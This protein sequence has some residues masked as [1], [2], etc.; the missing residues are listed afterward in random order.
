[1]RYA[2]NLVPLLLLAVACVPK[3]DGDIGN[4]EIGDGDGD[5]D[6]DANETTGDGDGD[7]TGDGDGDSDPCTTAAQA[8]APTLTSEL[9]GCDIVVRFDYETLA[10]LGLSSRCGDYKGA[11]IGEPAA[12]MMSDCCSSGQLLSPPGDDGFYLFYSPPGDFGGVAA[13]SNHLVT[14]VFEATIIWHGIGEISDPS[15]WLDAAALGRGCESSVPAAQSYDLIFNPGAPID[16]MQLEALLAALADTSVLPAIASA[17]NT[18][19]RMVVLAYPR[20]VGA[21]D[22]KVAEYVVLLEAGA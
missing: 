12:R 10:P 1:M 20:T 3:D 2:A 16:P 11:F 22:P 5:G 15:E 17:G 13:I 8:L 4:A 9:G 18:V 14:R 7:G 19:Y 6:D 21:F